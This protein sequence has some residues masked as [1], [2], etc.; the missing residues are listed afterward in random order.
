MVAPRIGDAARDASYA[1]SKSCYSGMD[2]SICDECTV[3]EAVE[4]LVSYNVGCLATK[5]AEGEFALLPHGD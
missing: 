4:K 2:F 3:F 1:W 5:D